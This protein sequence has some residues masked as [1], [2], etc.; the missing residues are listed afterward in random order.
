MFVAATES[1]NRGGI[2]LVEPGHVLDAM[3]ISDGQDDA[4]VLDG[5]KGKGAAV[6][7]LV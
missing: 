2:A 4:G 5:G 1:P 6:S 7:D 3:P